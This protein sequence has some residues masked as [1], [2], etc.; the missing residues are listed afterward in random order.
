MNLPGI[1]HPGF[2]SLRNPSNNTIDDVFHIE[3]LPMEEGICLIKSIRKC[4]AMLWHGFDEQLE[5]HPLH[6]DLSFISCKP[7]KRTCCKYRTS[8]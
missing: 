3:G 6:F 7:K 8:I 4:L 2:P 1:T 5:V